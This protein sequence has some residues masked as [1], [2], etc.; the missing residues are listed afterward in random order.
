M[1]KAMRKV[2]RIPGT[3][4]HERSARISKS[5]HGYDASVPLDASTSKLLK[6]A[7][8]VWHVSKPEAVR[9]A[10][11]VADLSP[12]PEPKLSPIEA[13]HELQRRLNLT[14]A[15]AIEWQNAVRDS[16]R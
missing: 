1:Q 7:S 14:P 2:R 9:R 11:E 10:L 4:R 8:R 15:K 12:D 5:A 13:L 16:R 6:R 3:S